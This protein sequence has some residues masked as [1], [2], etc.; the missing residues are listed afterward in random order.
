MSRIKGPRHLRVGRWG[1]RLAAGYLRLAGYRILDRNFRC[2][3]GEIDI[4]ARKRNLL[5]FVEVRTRHAGSL[6][7]PLETID[8]VKIARTVNAAKIYLMRFKRPY[9]YCRFDILGITTGTLFTE[10]FIRHVKDAFNIN[11]GKYSAG[12]SKRNR[13]ET[14]AVRE[15]G[16]GAPGGW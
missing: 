11:S 7:H 2:P 12:M 1:E 10:R 8:H 3:M 5:V 14:R 15:K 9:P 13:R 6:Q 16:K 4:I